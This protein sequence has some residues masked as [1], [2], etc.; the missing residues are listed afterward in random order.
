MD[1][2]EEDDLEIQDVPQFVDPDNEFENECCFWLMKALRGRNTGRQLK[3]R[4]FKYGVI[5]F[6]AG[7]PMLVITIVQRK[8]TPPLLFLLVVTESHRSEQVRGPQLLRL[9]GAWAVS[10]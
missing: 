6:L 1:F 7:F 2:D 5:N 8:L 3:R 10:D 4:I 9:E